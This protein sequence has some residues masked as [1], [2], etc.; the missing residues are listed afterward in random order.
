MEYEYLF[1]KMLY[2]TL[3]T[4]IKGRVFTKIIDDKLV[5]NITTREGIN[6]E[7]V[8]GDFANKLITGQISP[9]AE[10]Y[11]VLREYKE[12]IRKHFFY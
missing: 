7:R 1:T 4:T 10:A 11:A 2:D 6:Y 8:V 12:C 9:D 5:I 3:K